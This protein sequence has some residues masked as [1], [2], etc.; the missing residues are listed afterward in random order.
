MNKNSFKI[1]D[2]SCLSWFGSIMTFPTRTVFDTGTL[3]DRVQGCSQLLAASPSCV[4]FSFLWRRFLWGC[5]SNLEKTSFFPLAPVVL[6]II[7]YHDFLPIPRRDSHVKS[8]KQHTQC[9]IIII[10]IIICQISISYVLSSA[11]VCIV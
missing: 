1:L 2:V 11:T 4:F 8:D 10:I 7:I 6:I 5:G 3:D 9:C